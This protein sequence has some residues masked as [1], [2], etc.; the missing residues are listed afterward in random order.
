MRCGVEDFLCIPVFFIAIKLFCFVL[1]R[2]YVN[3]DNGTRLI[4]YVES[5]FVTKDIYMGQLTSF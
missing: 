1:H 3:I 5:D 2:I 4:S